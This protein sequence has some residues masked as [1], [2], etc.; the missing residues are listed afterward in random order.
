MPGVPKALARMRHRIQHTKDGRTFV[1]GYQPAESRSEQGA[2]RWLAQAAMHGQPPLDGAIDLRVAAFMPVP[3]SWS[4][5]KQAAALSGE[6][7][8]TGKPDADN[9]LKQ[10][11]DGISGIAI[12]DD[13]QVTEATIWKRYSDTPRLVIEI[14]R[15]TGAPA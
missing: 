15:A 2:I 4:K 8:P 6:V 10:A 14:R 13:A 12:R 5:R 9:L 1:Q 3:Q 7:R 11:G